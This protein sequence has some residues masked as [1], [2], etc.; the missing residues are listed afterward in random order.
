[1]KKILSIALI[2]A[3]LYLCYAGF[4]SGYR[5]KDFIGKTS[6]EIV[7]QYGSFDFTTI[8]VREDGLY[9]NCKCGYIVQESSVKFGGTS[10]E[11]MFFIVFDEN[12]IAVSCFE[13]E[14]PAA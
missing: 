14:T 13:S 8:A 9:K 2:L 7:K 4:S 6:A 1:M 10:R 5:E 11:M 12:G 3:V